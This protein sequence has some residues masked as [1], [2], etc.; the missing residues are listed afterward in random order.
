MKMY[1]DTGHLL[2]SAAVNNRE[3]ILF[4]FT[5]LALLGVIASLQKG[6]GIDCKFIQLKV[7]SRDSF[8][9]IIDE[10]CVNSAVFNSL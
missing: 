1:L 6:Y 3:L 4:S 9:F 10:K 8:K 2:L 5:L 7:L